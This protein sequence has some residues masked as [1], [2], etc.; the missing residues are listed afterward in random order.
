MS[1]MFFIFTLLFIAIAI[2]IKHYNCYWFISGYN[3]ASK[4]QKEKIDIEGL[5]RLTGNF[6]FMLA[7]IFASA[8]IFA[9]YK[10]IIG[11]LVSMSPLVLLIPFMLVKA[12]K[13]NYMSTSEKN[14]KAIVIAVIVIMILSTAFAGGLMLYGS[15]ETKVEIG[16]TTIGISA[17]Y[18]IRYSFS[19]I[20]EVEL[21]DTMP[22]VINKLD[23]FDMGK[24]RKGNF[25]LK[26]LG[27]ARLYVNSEKGP[28]IFIKKQDKYIIISLKDGDKTEDLFFRLKEAIERSK[29][30]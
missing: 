10:N 18:S 2:A 21:R 16:E 17:P 22:E 29:R 13:Y 9:L 26:D 8:G 3:T 14:S 7:A 5:A 25:K 4:E 24:L 12:Q 19:D 23:G 30:A 27:G 6:C 15:R 11:V 28:Y 1:I 20:Q